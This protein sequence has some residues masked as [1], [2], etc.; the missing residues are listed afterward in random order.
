MRHGLESYFGSSVK[1][2]AEIDWD[3]EKER[4]ALLQKIVADADRVGELARQVQGQFSE[5]A[6]SARV[7]SP[8]RP[9]A[10]GSVPRGG[11]QRQGIVE[12]AELLGQLLLQEVERQEDGPALKD[13]V[14]R[15]RIPSV[16]DPEM[17]HGRKS[18]R[19]RFDRHKA[20][21][22]VDT[23]S[24]L[25]TA[26]DILPG[27]AGDNTGV[28]ELVGQS[29]E[30]TGI[31]VEET[32]GDAAYGDGGTRQAFADAG[33]TLIAKVPGRPNKAYFPKEDFQIDLAAGT[34]T[35]PAGQVTHTLHTTG[36]RT[37]RLGQVYPSQSFQF[38]PAVCGLCPLRS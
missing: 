24:Q 27:N 16:H 8:R 11:P 34:C 14:S 22:V 32:I 35:C 9:P 10:P 1:G 21:V 37:N 28:L 5:E 33:R 7:S 2:E 12:A 26:V 19:K 17:R 23:D 6:P 20:A 29:E 3:K 30:N 15:D 18:S 38:D 31:E 13:G 4:R 36:T 25:V